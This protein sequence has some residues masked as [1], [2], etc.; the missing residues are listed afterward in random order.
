M[1][2]IDLVKERYSCRKFSDRVVEKE[3][4]DLILEAGRLA[5]TAKNQ[6][7][8]TIYVIENE[9]GLKKLNELTPCIY[10]AKTV[11]LFTYHI[12]KDWQNPFENE[13]R[14]GVEDVAIVATHVMLEAKDLGIDSCWLNYYPNKLVEEAFNISKDEKSVLLLPIGYAASN[15]TPSP[16]HTKKKDIGELVKYL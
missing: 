13:I 6:Q 7:P 9:E 5:P 12:N 11:L 16:Q 15:S 8:F 2:F 10:G 14:S 1:N 3:K 4:L